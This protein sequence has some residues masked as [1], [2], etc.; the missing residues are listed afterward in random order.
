MASIVAPY[1][2]ALYL[3]KHGGRGKGIIV[4]VPGALDARNTAVN[5][6]LSWGSWGGSFGR[7][8]PGLAGSSRSSSAEA[9][10][11]RACCASG[12]TLSC[13]GFGSMVGN[14]AW[15]KWR[16]VARPMG[17]V[18]AACRMPGRNPSISSAVPDVGD[19]G[20]TL[21]QPPRRAKIK[22]NVG[23]GKIFNPKNLIQKQNN[24]KNPIVARAARP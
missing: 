13:A 14:V 23:G 17:Q 21:P 9:T 20:I 16:P 4:N 7:T 12:V 2:Y 11:R 5:C 6:E 3:F 19:V 22:K 24:Q 15:R 8:D 1:T 18:R 10:A